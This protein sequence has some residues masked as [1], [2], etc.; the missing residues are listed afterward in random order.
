MAFVLEPFARL[1]LLDLG[2][3]AASVLNDGSIQDPA[4]QL[5][6]L[7]RHVD[8]ELPGEWVVLV[9]GVVLLE[10]IDDLLLPVLGLDGG[11][12]DHLG[13]GVVRELLLDGH[14][15]LLHAAELH[16]HVDRLLLGPDPDTRH[17][18]ELQHHVV[19]L[20]EVFL[21]SD[22]QVR[23]DF[24]AW[25]LPQSIDLEVPL[26]LDLA[27]DNKNVLQLQTHQVL[28]QGLGVVVGEPLGKVDVDLPPAISREDAVGVGVSLARCS[29]V[30]QVQVSKG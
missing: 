20:G 24:L 5:G 27:V 22:A 12:S 6:H 4:G 1:V 3:L 14:G 2:L 29:L 21:N 25:R 8:P 18:G 15:L 30:G 26:H 7:S 9:H 11:G 19:G 17:V 13:D 16:G 10:T 28:L 23:N